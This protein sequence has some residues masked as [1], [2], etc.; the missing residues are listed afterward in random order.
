MADALARNPQMAP[1]TIASLADEPAFDR[2]IETVAA[3][4]ADRFTLKVHQNIVFRRMAYVDWIDGMAAE[5]LASIDYR[6]FVDLCANLISSIARNRVVSFSAMTRDP[7][8]KL[9][10]VVLKYP[11]EVTALAVGAALYRLRVG[12]LTGEDA[13]G[14]LSAMIIE[15]AAANLSRHPEAAVKFRELL[16]LSTP[17]G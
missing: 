16:Q 15:N 6:S 17:W 14:G 3:A 9:I 8:D 11:N 4:I 5:N 12:E 7:D 13:G 10:G 1:W 2:L